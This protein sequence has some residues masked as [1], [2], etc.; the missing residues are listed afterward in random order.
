VFP[1]SRSD[2][3]TTGSSPRFVGVTYGLYVD[4]IVKNVDRAV[5]SAT[6]IAVTSQVVGTKYRSAVSP[7]VVSQGY[8]PSGSATVY[9]LFKVK[10]IGQ[11]NGTNTDVK[12][13][14]SNI[15]FE[16]DQDYPS[17]LLNVRNFSDT[18]QTPNY[19]ESF[20][21][22]L[23]PTANNYILKVIG[24]RFQKIVTD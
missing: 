3:R 10:H 6:S 14:I 22:C 18:D 13:E 17:F 24:D 16:S 9:E 15:Y 21:V 8:G 1:T 7:I 5:A 12:I 23:D 20:N 4:T 2:V 19:I 11:G